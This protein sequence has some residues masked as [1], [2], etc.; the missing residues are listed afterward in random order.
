[1]CSGYMALI[2]SQ[3]STQ[4]GSISIL[5]MF[6]S[7]STTHST[8]SYLAYAPLRNMSLPPHVFTPMYHRPSFQYTIVI[9]NLEGSQRMNRLGWRPKC[10]CCCESTKLVCVRPLWA[11]GMPRAVHGASCQEPSPHPP[12]FVHSPVSMWYGL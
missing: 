1:M 10:V 6:T 4:Q 11:W 2:A 9:P 12:C 7:R 3:N 5:C 8:S